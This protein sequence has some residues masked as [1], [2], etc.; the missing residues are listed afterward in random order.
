MAKNNQ[1]VF[2]RVRGKIVPIKVKDKKELAH[3][4]KLIATGLA[5]SLVGGGISRLSQKGAK[6]ALKKSYQASKLSAKSRSRAASDIQKTF[7][8]DDK[9][10]NRNII[11]ARKYSATSVALSKRSI[12][13][14]KVSSLTRLAASALGG[15]IVTSGLERG[16][17][18]LGI[19]ESA[20]REA[21]TAVAG[22]IASYAFMLG[23]GKF[24]ARAKSLKL[25][26]S[27]NQAAKVTKGRIKKR[28]LPD[29]PVQGEL[30]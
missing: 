11:R 25:L 10:D 22:Q 29:R 28:Y 30:F 27:I 2:R 21:I 26:K 15:G 8:F 23:V 7:G 12:K 17:E 16:A 5:T 20:T 18:A 4:G 13:F 9:F 14:T 19:K 24:G 6:A 1:V 3:S